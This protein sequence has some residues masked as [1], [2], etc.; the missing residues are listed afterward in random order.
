M[1][2]IIESLYK[3]FDDTFVLK[4]V[5]LKLNDNHIYGFVG[6]NGSGKSVL[7]KILC[8]LYYP[9][10]GHVIIDG[11]DIHKK[12]VF[13]KDMRVLIEKPNFL[14]NLSGLENLKLLASIQNK[15]TENDIIKTLKKVN[16]EKDMTKLYHKYSLGMKQ[17][18]AIAQVLMEDPKIMIFDEPLNGIEEKT[19]NI[20]RQILLDEKSKGKIILI[21]SHIKDDIEKM[22]DVI[23]NVNDGEISLVKE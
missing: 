4:N 12:D 3:K 5:N 18:L 8:G 9:T 15:I 21:A 19:A 7:F 10:E 20:I 14:P 11:I 1:E 13:P 2:I 16:L 23:F 6:R 17:K 22:A